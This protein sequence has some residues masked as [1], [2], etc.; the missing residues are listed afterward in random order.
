MYCIRVAVGKER[1]LAGTYNSAFIPSYISV[2][3]YRGRSERRHVVPGYIFTIQKENKAILVPEEEWHIIE[4]LSDIQPSFVDDM[5]KI[6]SGPLL[7]LDHLV[8][9]TTKSKIQIQADLLGE[10]R[11][12]WI[13][14]KNSDKDVSSSEKQVEANM[15]DRGER[16]ME[17][18]QEQINK[19]LADA[20]VNGVHAAA[21][22]A[23]VAWQTVLRWARKAGKQIPPKA[24]KK[25]EFKQGKPFSTSATNTNLSPLELEN[26]ILRERVTFL[27]E[28]VQKLQKAVAELK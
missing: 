9:S 4:A 6:V 14:V 17:N 12:Y 23:G 2:K 10:R 15:R 8:V 26:A 22:K 16:K 28:K 11:T 7:G 3:G 5:G 13:K 18:T 1:L 20:E 27:E 24:K 19:I 25:K 21:K